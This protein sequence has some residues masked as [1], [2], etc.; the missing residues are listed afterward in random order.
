MALY[1]DIIIIII[2][3]EVTLGIIAC[4]YYYAWG[5][6]YYV[7]PPI[8]HITSKEVYLMRSSTIRFLRIIE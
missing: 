5:E 4:N 3:R 7:Y 2:S 1:D 6:E 8:R